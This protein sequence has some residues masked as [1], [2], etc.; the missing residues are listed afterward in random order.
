MDLFSGAGADCEN[1]AAD[2]GGTLM[3][4]LVIK[5]PDVGE[6]TAQAE[7]SAWL[8][9]VGDIVAEDQNLA[10]I[11]TDKATVEMP[12]PA[13]GTI[14]ALHGAPGDM[15]AVGADLAELATEGPDSAPAPD[16][17]PPM[18]APPATLP[19]VHQK[20]GRPG[21]IIASP[22]VRARAIDLAVDLATIVG[23][24]PSGRITHGDLDAYLRFRSQAA[25]VARAAT[26]D[27]IVEEIR[28]VGIRRQIAER[29][30]QAKRAIPHFTYV[31]EVDVSELEG[32]RASLNADGG[33]RA[34]KLTILPFVIVAMIRVIADFPQMN[35]Q[36]DDA[37]EVVRRFSAVHLGVAT[38]TDK[39]LLV[40]V[41]SHAERLGLRTLARAIADVAERARSGMAQR[42]ELTGSTITVTSLGRLGG[43]VTTPVI[44]RPEVAIVG[45]NKVVAR[46]IVR[47]RAI[48]IGQMMNLSASFDHRVIDGFVAAQFI[49]RV[50]VL[51]ETPAKLFMDG[52]PAF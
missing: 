45:V 17:A 32:L 2:R 38:Q 19:P 8:V 29:M 16:P 6:G 35:A 24:A 43:I 23:T 15:I 51:L 31:E 12:S 3:A 48:V 28:I 10:E 22:A 27:D 26:D 33:A 52:G 47:D 40:P 18:D 49:Q 42:A 25:P 20:V 21:K 13:A 37:N 44:N 11:T 14:V 5:M 41:I 4:R 34:D 46:P 1:A 39:G 7:L 9:A 50:K 36:Y 30:Q